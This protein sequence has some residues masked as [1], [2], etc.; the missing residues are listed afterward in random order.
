MAC[1]ITSTWFIQNSV[2]NFLKWICRLFQG[3][4]GF[5]SQG[6]NWC[7]G[8]WKKLKIYVWTQ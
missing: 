5:I 2:L 6:N 1:D 7:N 8:Q 3:Q 4:Y